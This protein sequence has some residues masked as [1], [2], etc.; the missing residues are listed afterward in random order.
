MNENGNPQI[1]FTETVITR[2]ST[3]TSIPS[4]ILWT[5]SIVFWSSFFIREVQPQLVL[6]DV[7]DKYPPFG[8]ERKQALFA[9]SVQVCICL[10]GTPLTHISWWHCCTPWALLAKENRITIIQRVSFLILKC[11]GH[12]YPETVVVQNAAMVNQ[13][14]KEINHLI[15]AKVHYF[16]WLLIW[17][18]DISCKVE[19]LC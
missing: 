1:S 13:V 10:V 6:I 7:I 17:T 12:Y 14:N 19:P 15:H 9:G 8:F 5:T 16:S 2:S 18:V 4:R 11:V 3:L